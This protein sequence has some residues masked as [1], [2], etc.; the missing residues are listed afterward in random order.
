MFSYY[1]M[2]SKESRRVNASCFSMLDVEHPRRIQIAILMI[3]HDTFVVAGATAPVV[4]V[5]GAVDWVAAVVY[6]GL[7]SACFFFNAL[8]FVYWSVLITNIGELHQT[9]DSILFVISF[10]SALLLLLPRYSSSAYRRSIER[11]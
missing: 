1:L 7:L 6:V 5:A 10:H 11:D 2:S 9:T 3:N 4:V 8:Q